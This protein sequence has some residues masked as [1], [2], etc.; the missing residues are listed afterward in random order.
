[1]SKF[2]KMGEWRRKKG[3][4]LDSG[5]T[6]KQKPLK[7]RGLMVFLAVWTGLPRLQRRGPKVGGGTKFGS[8]DAKHSRS[9]RAPKTQAN[10]IFGHKKS[11]LSVKKQASVLAVWTG[12]EPATPCVTGMYSNQLNYQTVF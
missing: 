2:V 3:T 4:L 10:L 1:M 8:L 5:S 11:P 9:F 7:I 12:L 6:E